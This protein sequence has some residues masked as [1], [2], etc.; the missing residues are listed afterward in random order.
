MASESYLTMKEPVSVPQ[1]FRVP[2]G[3]EQPC[4]SSSGVTRL[5]GCPLVPGALAVSSLGKAC[6]PLLLC[7]PCGVLPR[8]DSSTLRDRERRKERR[9]SQSGEGAGR[10]AERKGNLGSAMCTARTWHH[11][12]GALRWLPAPEGATWPAAQHSGPEQDHLKPK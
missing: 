5:L 6:Q 11:Y 7:A 9:G 4:Y 1:H 3:P 10:G 2:G 12:A 8:G